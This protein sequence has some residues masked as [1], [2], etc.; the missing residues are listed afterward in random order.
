MYLT[1]EPP[2]KERSNEEMEKAMCNVKINKAPREDDVIAE[3][4]KNA[5]HELKRGYMH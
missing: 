2:V 5:N 1:A 4:I 3:L